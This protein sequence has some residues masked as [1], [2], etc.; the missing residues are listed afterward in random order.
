MITTVEE[1]LKNYNEVDLWCDL[2]N[3]KAIKRMQ[4]NI[5][6]L[7]QTAAIYITEESYDFYQKLLA[8]ERTLVQ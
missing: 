5:K 2:E 6:K 7:E 1:I 4:E 8:A 3:L